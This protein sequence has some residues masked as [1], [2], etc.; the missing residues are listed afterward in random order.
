ML[1]PISAQRRSIA[2]AASG[3]RTPLR[4]TSI[5][6][7]SRSK[8]GVSEKFPRRAAP[9]AASPISRPSARKASTLRPYRTR[10][11][12]AR[13]ATAS[14]PP[15]SAGSRSNVSADAEPLRA[16]EALRIFGDDFRQAAAEFGGTFF[17]INPQFSHGISPYR[18]EP[19]MRDILRRGLIRG[20]ISVVVRKP[21]VTR[22]PNAPWV[23]ESGGPTRAPFQSTP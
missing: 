15:L 19:G 11:A 17:Q 6:I 12:E 23:P 14:P 3:V 21:Q 8:R 13:F 10:Q 9:S 1:R 22:K 20:P 2:R 16:R 4:E 7:P 18:V 5:M